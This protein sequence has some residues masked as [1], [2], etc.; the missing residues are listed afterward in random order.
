MAMTDP[1]TLDGAREKVA[2]IRAKLADWTRRAKAGEV[3]AAGWQQYYEAVLPT[4]E[5]YVKG[6]EERSRSD[7]T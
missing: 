1:I 6:L 2:E 3:G 7:H 4:W 5:R